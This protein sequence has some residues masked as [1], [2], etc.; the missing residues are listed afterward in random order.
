MY[1]QQLYLSNKKFDKTEFLCEN[2]LNI[3]LTLR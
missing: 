3:N 1:F 2:A